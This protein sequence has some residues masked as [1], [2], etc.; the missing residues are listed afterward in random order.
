MEEKIWKQSGSQETQ[1]EEERFQTFNLM[2]QSF[3]HVV[4]FGIF[5]KIPLILLYCFAAQQ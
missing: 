3:E 4:L 2:Y 5:G 1:I